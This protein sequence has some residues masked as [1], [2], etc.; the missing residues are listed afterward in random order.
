MTAR[1]PPGGKQD[2]HDAGTSLVELMVT[3]AIMSIMMVIFTG[4]I[5]Q[6]YRATTDTESLTTAQSQLRLAFQR[7]D[8][9]LRYA[10]WISEPGLV[11]TAWYVEFAGPA[12]TGCRQLRLE[13]VSP[14]GNGVD[15]EGQ[16]QLISWTPGAPPAAGDP[17]QTIAAQ[18]L[19]TG[20]A[21][22]FE[23]QAANGTPYASASADAVGTDF[24]TDFQRLRIQLTTRVAA[25]T[26]QVD[27]TFTALNTSR[28][29][30]ADN[31]CSEGRP[32]L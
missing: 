17:G 9:E 7:F 12:D 20:V 15:G 6:I 3:M 4:A 28:D 21:P 27:T 25:G 32:H 22:F 24:T 19:T 30:P 1:R 2:P 18:I 13:T 31:V 5:L 8:R 29:T 14:D 16:L 11:G 26:A 10:S 23:R